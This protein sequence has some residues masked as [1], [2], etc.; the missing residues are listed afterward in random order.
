M[1]DVNYS[2]ADNVRVI[3]DNLLKDN[4]S[5][6]EDSYN[7][8][9]LAYMPFLTNNT[10]GLDLVNIG[11]S[12]LFTA[13][14]LR[15]DNG[16]IN[17]TVNKNADPII[18]QYNLNGQLHLPASTSPTGLYYKEN[19]TTTPIDIIE[20]TVTEETSAGFYINEDTHYNVMFNFST[21]KITERVIGVFNNHEVL[22]IDNEGYLCLTA[23]LVNPDDGEPCTV[24]VRAQNPLMKNK[25]YHIGI[26][27]A[28]V[29]R[30]Y[31][32]YLLYR[33][34]VNYYISEAWASDVKPIDKSS[35][36]YSSGNYTLFNISNSN[37]LNSDSGMTID[38]FYIFD[39]PNGKQLDTYY[40]EP[41]V[42]IIMDFPI[43]IDDVVNK[44]KRDV[45]NT[46][47]KDYN[48]EDSRITTRNVY[49]TVDYRINTTRVPIMFV[50][51]DTK[52][53]VQKT[54]SLEYGY[55]DLYNIVR[56][57]IISLDSDTAKDTI[58]RSIESDVSLTTIGE[59]I[60]YS[61]SVDFSNTTIRDS[62]NITEIKNIIDKQAY[63][64]VTT[65]INRSISISY[66]GE[67]YPINTKRDVNKDI[68]NE[69]NYDVY[70]YIQYLLIDPIENNTQRIVQLKLDSDI[71]LA[72]THRD[73]RISRDFT[74]KNIIRSVYVN[75]TNTL[76]ALRCVGG[77]NEYRIVIIRDIYKDVT[78][79]N[80]FDIKR[81][82]SIDLP[83]EYRYN[84][85]R[86][87]T[88][89]DIS[90]EYDSCRDIKFLD[91][92]KFNIKRNSIFSMYDYYDMSRENR[93][94]SE[95]YFDTMR[96]SRNDLY[97][98]VA[99]LVYDYGFYNY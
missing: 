63:I 80:H 15:L 73:V 89:I 84:S 39:I 21:D 37:G 57:N 2:I 4:I 58:Y 43:E 52:R 35:N 19:Y 62:Q 26:A 46:Y 97:K 93:D 23:F 44:T 11:D 53:D 98:P 85:T 13:D 29:N 69:E 6:M 87:D 27:R 72:S 65:P 36:I 66:N 31:R 51:S 33:G 64:T 40:E 48:H 90:E 94:I 82:P 3:N 38:E 61:T 24:P 54:Y 81:Y 14:N 70:R 77:M 83:E 20:N 22:Y 99:A 28:I 41:L 92:F 10:R 5:Y 16:I 68:I 75:V 1:S 88:Q 79:N 30:R 71:K 76:E 96:I 9:I 49:V 56:D 18:Q 45:Q 12:N 55:E 86:W 34:F 78:D 67:D 7:I 42:P 25:V 47:D 95:F 50:Y 32:Y 8:K 91:R 74:Y 59:R 60:N 17:K